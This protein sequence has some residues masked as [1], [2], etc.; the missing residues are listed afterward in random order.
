MNFGSVRALT[1]GLLILVT[2]LLYR[3]SYMSMVEAW[4]NSETYS[5]GFVIPLIAIFF[6]WQRRARAAMV[7]AK[8]W[9]PGLALI[10]GISII[11][12]ISAL[13]NVRVIEQFAAV[14]VIPAIIVTLYGPALTR[15]FTLP[16]AYL[17]FAVPFGQGLVPI[18]MEWTADFT[19]GALQIF[20]IPVLREGLHFS[21]AN[22]NFN[23][24]EACSG[25]RYLLASIATGTAF[26]F[27]AYGGWKKR[28]LF[29]LA[30][31]V[32]PIIANGIRA[33]AIV[34]IA[35]Y[36][37]MQLAV[38]IDHFIYGW[39][40]F[41]I[42]MLLLFWFGGRFADHDARETFVS[43]S[44]GVRRENGED[45]WKT[46]AAGI[47]LLLL[48]GFGPVLSESR[49]QDSNNRPIYF[50]VGTALGEGWQ[51][52]IAAESAW[53]LAFQGATRNGAVAY[54]NGDVVLELRMAVYDIQTQGAE[55]VNFRNRL[56]D[57][58][59]RA[60]TIDVTKATPKSGFDYSAAA[61]NRGMTNYI[62]L[63]WYQYGAEMTTN[64]YYAKWLELRSLIE[65]VPAMVVAVGVDS[66][67]EN[68]I[69]ILTDFVEGGARLI[70]DCVL[71]QEPDLICK[72]L[73][74][75][76]DE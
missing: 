32:T 29:I 49:H 34:L 51:G 72:P 64:S 52:P 6:A 74:S 8:V 47:V 68:A 44:P 69:A 56:A 33:F 5:H 63:H 39:F 53:D 25:V 21:T 13:V 67:H 62:L 76:P 58:D 16:L 50:P 10:T 14:A 40:F 15:V 55:L 20:G 24:V 43:D 75:I 41:G 1:F 70:T 73:K 31:I 11:W 22:G 45:V 35:H 30:A 38:G 4:L 18:F 37:N 12:T 2:A 36:S 3:Q 61:I 60:R 19:V 23:I 48:V 27:L 46:V 57:S 65:P 42:I 7:H 59:W 9:W 71:A 54:S 28:A 26:A 66:R 17:F